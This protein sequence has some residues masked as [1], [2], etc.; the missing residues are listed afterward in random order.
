MDNV[1]KHN[2][3][4]RKKYLNPEAIPEQAGQNTYAARTFPNFLG[5]EAL[6]AVTMESKIF[7]IIIPYS[8][9]RTRRFGGIYYVHLQGQKVSQAKFC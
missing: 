4:K 1:Q 5:F 6:T 3:C 7:Y 2:N 8:S 9:E